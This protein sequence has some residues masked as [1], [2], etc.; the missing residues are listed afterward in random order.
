MTDYGMSIMEWS[1]V[2]Q[3]LCT[4]LTFGFLWSQGLSVKNNL[5]RDRNMC[6]II[7]MVSGAITQLAFG[8][9]IQFLPLTIANVVLCIL[10]F[11]N[12][13]AAWF[14]FKESISKFTIMIMIISFGAINL[15]AFASPSESEEALESSTMSA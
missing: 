3:T 4:I 6:L 2:R 8:Q 10:P 5:P 1:A 15:L 12:A 13:V 11:V 9:A 7:I 14:I